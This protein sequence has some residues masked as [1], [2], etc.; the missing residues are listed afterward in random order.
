MP[1][2][3]ILASYLQVSK[4]YAAASILTFSFYGAGSVLGD[5][6]LRLYYRDI[7]DL[8]AGENPSLE[9]WPALQAIF[10]KVVIVSLL[11]NLLYRVGDYLVVYAQAS[12]MRELTNTAFERL[13]RHSYGFF[14]GSFAGSLVAKVKRY[15]RAFETIYD[16]L[17]FEFWFT[18]IQLVG[19]FVV[20]VL[21]MPTLATF[22]AVWCA[23]YVLMSYGFARFRFQ[24]DLKESE[25]DSAVTG[26]LSDAI[27]NILNLKMFATG[28]REQERFGSY[29][30]QEY[31]AR[32]TAWHIGNAFHGVQ[33]ICM[34]LLEVAG[35]YLTLRLWI[36]GEI[37]AGTVILVQSYFAMVI[38]K[39]WGIGRAISDTYKAVSDAE[40]M[41]SILRAP[42]EVQDP[43]SPE[44]L[45]IRKGNVQFDHVSFRYRDGNP[46]F[47]D[48]SI[49]VPSGQRVGIVGHSGAGK[50]TLFKLLLRFADVTEGGIRI[51]E[52]DIRA[53]A[54]DDL[55]RSI[56]YVPQE[57]ILFHRSL[58]E[59]IAYARPNATK[60]EVLE[61]ARR[62]HAH[63]FV[64]KMPKGYDT[65][66]GERGVRLS[67]GERQRIA[68]ARVILKDAPIL[69]LDEATSSLD[70][71]SEKFIQEQIA[72][73]MRGR[74]TLAIAHRIST[75][76]QMD[77]I[78]VLQ[79]GHIAEDGTHAELLKKNGV[80][81]ELWSHQS[82]GFLLDDDE[83]EEEPEHEPLLDL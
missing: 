34:A 17:L 28:K 19:V 46:I 5:I 31:R 65:L 24:Y 50:S 68:L 12:T 3:T 53:I 82:H 1:I 55:R 54:Q 41:V 30:Q 52:Q 63:D 14:T 33:G 57:P 37:T 80:Y 51:D 75:I 6:V 39:I 26:Q 81:A 74:T 48:F 69:L 13:Q 61:A 76:T 45:R 2:R 23:F 66:V 49:T 73:L 64:A 38:G 44:P 8:I 77:R 18:G 32:R 43:L 60:G 58:G 15:T 9:M 42:I 67:G 22:F 36:H 11:Y 59:N 4:P 72:D 35:M 29:T 47:Q 56:S 71:I 70:S 79:D 62:A 25:A 21:T 78:I 27:T 16:K 40:E 20:L 10:L 7:F 83:P